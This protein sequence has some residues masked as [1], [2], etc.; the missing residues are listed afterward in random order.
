MNIVNNKAVECYN[1]IIQ[2][3]EKDIRPTSIDKYAYKAYQNKA[4]LM[5][6][7]LCFKTAIDLLN[8]AEAI[9]LKMDE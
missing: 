7:I 8:K 5:Y 9:V 1:Y 4:I 6:D 3:A 2:E